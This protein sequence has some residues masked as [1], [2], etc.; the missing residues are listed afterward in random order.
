MQ[1]KR[2]QAWRW[3]GMAHTQ[4]K[5][6]ADT[7]LLES[8]RRDIPRERVRRH[9]SS[10]LPHL[11]HLAG[12]VLDQRAHGLAEQ[13]HVTNGAV[14]L[15]GLVQVGVEGDLL[16]VV[17]LA[18]VH[19]ALA[20]RIGGV[21][22]L[23]QRI[24]HNVGGAI[25]GVELADV[26]HEVVL[27]DLA[28][29]VLGGRDDL[30]G[31]H[32]AALRGEVDA[33]TGALRH[34]ACGI[35]DERAAVL[36]APRAGVLRDRVRLHADDLTTLDA[37][38][39]ALTDAL[40]VLLDALLVH[41]GAGAHGHVVVLGEDPGVEVRR[42]VLTNV[43]LSALLVVLHLVLRDA[44]ALLEG[45]GVLIVARLDLLGH[46]AVGT[47][48]ADDHVH[49]Q[50]LLHALARIALGI[51]EVV[52]GQHVGLLLRL[53]HPHLSEEAVDER[54]SVLR[55]TLAQEV[56]ENLAAH[57][58]DVLVVLERAADLH[59]VVRGRDHRHLAHLPV[60]EVSWQV[61]LA[62]HAHRDGAAARLAVVQLAL[63]EV[64]LA[65][66]LGE[67]VRAASAA[68]ATA[69]HG[70]TELAALRQP[71]TRADN[72]LRVPDG[73]LVLVRHHGGASQLGRLALPARHDG[74]GDR[75]GSSH[76]RGR[77]PGASRGRGL[78]RGS[79]TAEATLRD[80]CLLGLTTHSEGVGSG[81][82]LREQGRREARRGLHR[83][84][85][86]SVSLLTLS[87]GLL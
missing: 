68:G 12:V 62:H 22:E 34:V 19:E 17:E 28:R 2:H 43:H 33:L 84:D 52:V 82:G 4:R 37:R 32:E 36:G 9:H 69:D 14:A 40:L 59:L 73:A 57:H 66:A 24:Q 47:I 65:A 87:L 51:A 67:R 10:K 11:W 60:D 21:E 85:W 70:H 71:R 25:L 13:H 75:H 31:A 20:R 74:R 76:G 23:L 45:N 1:T 56:V 50:S 64:G 77:G 79:S 42:H 8:H 58:A 49:L 63:N 61:K 41:H 5:R 44:H 30:R 6:C 35:A 81:S 39:R 53:R 83:H 29:A 7:A 86:S 26:L 48:G 46:A 78:L 80:R 72:G 16:H 3:V 55:S 18:E 38:R 15:H 54:R 27:G